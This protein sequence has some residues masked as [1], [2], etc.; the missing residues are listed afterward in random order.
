MHKLV[1]QNEGMENFACE[2]KAGKNTFGR[3]DGNSF[4]LDDDKVSERHCEVNLSGGEVYVRDL[5][6]TNGTFIGDRR[7]TESVLLPGQQ[8]HIGNFWFALEVGDAKNGEAEAPAPNAEPTPT[9][10]GYFGSLI[11]FPETTGWIIRIALAVT[12]GCLTLF[13]NWVFPYYPSGWPVLIAALVTA[14]WIT[15]PARGMY[16]ALATQLLPVARNISLGFGVFSLG[17]PA[18]M[19]PYGFLL[20]GI[21]ALLMWCPLLSWLLPAIPLAAGLRSITRGAVVGVVV[22]FIAEAS[23]LI[24]RQ[25]S[26]GML[27][28]VPPPAPALQLQTSPV[29]SLGDFAW[30]TGDH[31]EGNG[32]TLIANSFA[33][34]PILAG[35]LML[36]GMTGALVGRFR[37]RKS[38]KKIPSQ[39]LAIGI[40][41]AFLLAGDLALWAA[42]GKGPGGIGAAIFGIPICTAL[43]VVVAPYLEAVMRLL[44]RK[45]DLFESEEAANRKAIIVPHLE[46]TMPPGAVFISYARTQKDGDISDDAGFARRIRDTLQFLE[47]DV[48]L[49]ESGLGSGDEYERKIQRYIRN[50]SIFMPIISQTTE[51]RQEGYFRKEWYWAAQRLLEF[52]GTTRKFVMPIV[53]DD[54]PLETAKVPDEFRKFQWIT[55]PEGVI[56]PV[57]VEN[58]KVIVREIRQRD[59]EPA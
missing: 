19:E 6:S 30:A 45:V 40:G 12:A 25:P 9:G 43:V 3:G 22:C 44:A 51:E 8:L 50:C 2:L 57:S 33:D 48:W 52:T 55:A 35:Q 59:F 4:S 21:A 28:A 32:L 7:I 31:S 53:V 42:L 13:V 47:I 18:V 38:F 56:P 58:I 23:M 46:P 10:T 29:K 20:T 5:N 16:V 24:G 39:V 34:Q 15:S 41:G 36:W 37:K 14:L 54:T 26:I 27:T 49:D 11:E 1:I 17:L